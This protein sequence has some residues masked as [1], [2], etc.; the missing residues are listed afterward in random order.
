MSAVRWSPPTVRTHGSIIGKKSTTPR[1]TSKKKDRKVSLGSESLEFNGLQDSP[2]V[3]KILESVSKATKE[4]ELLLKQFPAI[5]QPAEVDRDRVYRERG[6]PACSAKSMSAHESEGPFFH[7][8]A[9]KRK[10]GR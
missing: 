7:E 3:H 10:K 1:T 5:T 4:N 9:K 2:N 8:V 6:T